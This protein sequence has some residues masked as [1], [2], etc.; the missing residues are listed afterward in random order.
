MKIRSLARKPKY[1]NLGQENLYYPNIIYG[2]WRTTRP[3]EKV[4][5]DTTILKNK[6]T[7]KELTMYIDVYKNDMIDSQRYWKLGVHDIG[8]DFRSF[9]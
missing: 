7:S 4:V 1:V 3:F 8:E 9:I 6:Y 2:D 5:T